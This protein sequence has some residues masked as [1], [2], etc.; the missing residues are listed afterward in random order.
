MHTKVKFLWGVGVDIENIEK[1][2]KK[3]ILANRFFLNKIY[4]A[5]ELKY[6]LAKKSPAKHLAARYAGK[7]AVFKAYSS[8]GK[9]ITDYKK[10]E[11]INLKRGSPLVR[12][13]NASANL[14][15]TKISLSHCTDKAIAFVIVFGPLKTRKNIYCE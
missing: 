15:D 7:E 8:L 10:I 2:A 5:K 13:H 14:F 12:I 4:T 6:C 11:I 9:K 1:F 3:D